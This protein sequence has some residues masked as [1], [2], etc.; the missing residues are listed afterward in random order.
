MNANRKVKYNPKAKEY[1]HWKFAT[2][3]VQTLREDGKAYEV[4]KAVHNANLDVVGLQEVKR[5]NY[6]EATFNI[7]GDKYQLFWQGPK[8]KRFAGVGLIIKICPY[9][10]IEDIETISPR[11][12]IAR[13]KIHNLNYKFVVTYAPTEDKTNAVK[14][15]FYHQLCKFSVKDESK[16][17]QKLIVLG[18]MNATTTITDKHCAFNGIKAVDNVE[19]NNNGQRLID[20]CREK[21][22]CISS[23]FYIHKKI[24]PSLGTA[25][26]RE[27]GKN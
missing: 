25:L 17:H 14:D 9:I 7:S 24:R 19:S 21:T 12:I 2:I 27:Q 6:G 18:D 4:V 3:N 22:L 16:K 5:L 23:T 15:Q 11:L 13:L 26:I 20:F 8:V 1:R 10:Q